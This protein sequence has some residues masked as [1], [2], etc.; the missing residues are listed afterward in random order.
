LLKL[1][2]GAPHNG[3]IFGVGL[4]LYP[5]KIEEKIPMELGCGFSRIQVYCSEVEE[6]S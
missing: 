4:R 3:W 1:D 6:S 5:K 2:T